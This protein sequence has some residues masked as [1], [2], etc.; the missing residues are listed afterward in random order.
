MVMRLWNYLFF[1]PGIFE[2][3]QN[4][5]TEWNRGGYL[6]TGAAHCGACH[7]P[8]NLFGADRRGRAIRRR[9]DREAG[10]RRG[11]TARRAAG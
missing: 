3:D 7:T 2:P 11:S 4:K 8:K 10:S 6:V 5:S 1:Q 9:T